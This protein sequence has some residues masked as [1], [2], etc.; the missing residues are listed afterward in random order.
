MSL[1]HTFVKALLLMDVAFGSQTTIALNG[2][3]LFNGTSINNT[4]VMGFRCKRY[5]EYG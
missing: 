1:K 3:Y 4:A 2:L 5:F